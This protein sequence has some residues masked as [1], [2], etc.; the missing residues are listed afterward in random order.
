MSAAERLGQARAWLRQDPDAET[1]DELAGIITRAAAG[2]TLCRPVPCLARDG[3]LRRI[4][5]SRPR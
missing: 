2:D 5:Q 1:R 4:W 3:E